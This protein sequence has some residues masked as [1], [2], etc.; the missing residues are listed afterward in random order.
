MLTRSLPTKN[1]LFAVALSVALPA[2]AYE[3]YNV[4]ETVLN[5]NLEA[6][7]AAMHSDE[8]YA[9]FGNRSSG[10]SSWREGYIKYGLSGTQGLRGNG[11]LYGF[12]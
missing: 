9:V 5:A 7:F 8:N 3:I 4:D 12:V 2:H 6:V 11:S 10:S 1:T